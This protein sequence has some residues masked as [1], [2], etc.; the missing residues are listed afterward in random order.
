MRILVAGGTGV[1]GRPLVESLVQ[2]G[3]DVTASSHR[4]DHLAE[5][6]ALG[7]RAVLMDGLDA[8]AVRQAVLDIRP[9]VIVNQ[10]TA[11]AAPASDY[12][13]W[14]ATTNRLRAEGTATL[15]A[16]AAE[17]GA[18]RLVTQSA[19][20]MT[21]PDGD[22]PTDES[23]PLYQEA[24][25][26][27]RSHALANIAAESVVLQTPGVEGVVLRYGFLYGDGTALGP[28]GQWTTAVQEGGLP[29]VADGGG[30]YPFIHVRDA[31]NA[32]LQAVETG[33]PG[34]YN[35]VDDEPA[36]QADWIPY[37]ADLLDAP[38]P[39]RISE[40]DAL[41]QIGVH[42]VYYGT[43][44]RAASNAKAKADLGLA[45]QYPSWR[46]GFRGLVASADAR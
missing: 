45:L 15:M 32:T 40:A 38:A 16:A 36:R 17:V 11:L 3:H 13:S 27:L 21:S 34:I 8:A 1:L 25:E 28:G 39:R 44:L 4:G 43:Q 42:A 14:L 30:H 41:T 22:G 10:M 33:E 12:A 24:P 37:L 31:V 19:S 29:V 6:E 23:S 46:E 26:P 7:A 18:R 20:F 35:I 9:D 5:V 2:Q